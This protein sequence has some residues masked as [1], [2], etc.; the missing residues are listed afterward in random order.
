VIPVI[1]ENTNTYWQ[2]TTNID[3]DDFVHKD[4]IKEIQNN[5]IPK[6]CVLSFNNGYAYINNLESLLKIKW[7]SNPFYSLIENLDNIKT[8]K[9]IENH[10]EF[11][12]KNKKII[13]KIE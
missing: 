1:K 6:N 10:I 2:I 9:Y 13:K 3:S 5:F 4:F 8:T 11:Y 7:K 12:N